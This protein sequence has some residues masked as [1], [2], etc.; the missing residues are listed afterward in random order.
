[1]IAT[2]DHSD[3]NIVCAFHTALAITVG[4]TNN[5]EQQTDDKFLKQVQ[6]DRRVLYILWLLMCWDNWVS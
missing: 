3:R 2:A 1:M 6:R 4:N 5:A